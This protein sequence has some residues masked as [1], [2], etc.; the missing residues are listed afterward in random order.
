MD[1]FN[2][3]TA[4]MFASYFVQELRSKMKLTQIIY[5]D[6]FLEPHDE[7]DNHIINCQN[8]LFEYIAQNINTAGLTNEKFLD[9]LDRKKKD[10][11]ALVEKQIQQYIE[12]VQV[13]YV[14]VD[15]PRPSGN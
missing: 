2:G 14:N 15:E 6:E 1:Y 8:K 10:V 11:L 13:D 12:E 3:I 7:I 9:L 4:G 5:S